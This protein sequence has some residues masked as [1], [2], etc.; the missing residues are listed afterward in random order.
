MWERVN[1]SH[2]MLILDF[3]AKTSVILCMV[4]FKDIPENIVTKGVIAHLAKLL[5]DKQF[6]FFFVPHRC[7]KFISTRQRIRHAFCHGVMSF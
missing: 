5:F 7:Q 6:S 4:L 1:K 3:H 2:D